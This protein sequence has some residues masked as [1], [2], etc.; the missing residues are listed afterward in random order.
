MIVITLI[1]LHWIGDDFNMNESNP[2]YRLKWTYM[3][4][5]ILHFFHFLYPARD[6]Y[7]L[8]KYAHFI[9]SYCLIDVP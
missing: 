3:P 7:E 4:S 5:D 9:N 2:S 6:I 1:I 8:V